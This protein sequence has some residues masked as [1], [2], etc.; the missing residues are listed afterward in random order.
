MAYWTAKEP[1]TA[2]ADGVCDYCAT[3][4]YPFTADGAYE[5]QE[6]ITR[7]QADLAVAKERAPN[8]KIVWLMQSY[9]QPN[10]SGLR[11]PTAAEMED[12]AAIVYA[13]D[14]FGAL[15]YTWQFEGLYDDFL[16][17]HP[18]LYPVVEAIYTEQVLP[19]KNIHCVYLP[20]IWR[21]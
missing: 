16:F 3:W 13:S 6:L 14:V 8:S 19:L 4:Y 12:L 9:A 17:N 20:V 2:F 10:P 7:L 1:A 21:N 18:E 15:W 11:M 5:R